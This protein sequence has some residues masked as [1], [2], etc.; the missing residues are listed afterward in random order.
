MVI[1]VSHCW[2]GQK[3]GFKHELW[4]IFL[5]FFLSFRYSEAEQGEVGTRAAVKPA[6]LCSAH[7]YRS[8]RAT[9]AKGE[10]SDKVCQI[11][12]ACVKFLLPKKRERR[13]ADGQAGNDTQ[14]TVIKT[15]LRRFL[16]N[17]L[18]NKRGLLIAI[19]MVPPT[20]YRV[21]IVP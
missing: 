5:S 13:E 21:I 6:P 19:N 4:R 7:S 3:T 10:Q 1:K 9:V 2:C 16:F 17:Q 15:H 14:T 11:A 18:F 8:G 20:C 12:D